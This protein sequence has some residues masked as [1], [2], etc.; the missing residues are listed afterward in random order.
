[1]ARWRQRAPQ[2]LKSEADLRL[3]A[4]TGRVVREEGV[5]RWVVG[6]GMVLVIKEGVVVT[7]WPATGRERPVAV[8]HQ[9]GAN[10]GDEP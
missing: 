9:G 7:C 3:A 1:M 4:E 2:G 6:L 5:K 8:S 10:V